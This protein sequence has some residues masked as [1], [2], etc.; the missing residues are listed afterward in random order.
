[1]VD[2]GK[3]TY[4]FLKLAHW[5]LTDDVTRGMRSGGFWGG[6]LKLKNKYLTKYL[7]IYETNS[8]V[9]ISKYEM[10]AGLHS[11]RNTLIFRCHGPLKAIQGTTC[12]CSSRDII[13]NIMSLLFWC[14]ICFLYFAL[15]CNNTCRHKH[16]ETGSLGGNSSL[17]P[18]TLHTV[19]ITETLFCLITQS[20]HFQT[21]LFTSR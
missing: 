4:H 16:S 6:A 21:I 8:E 17:L 2:F 9:Y 15:F 11:N 3:D 5:W 14:R 12:T 18:C 10:Y 1:M 7:I 19:R 20:S 13:L